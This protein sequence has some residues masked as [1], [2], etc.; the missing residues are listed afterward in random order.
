MRFVIFF[1]FF[2]NLIIFVSQIIIFVLNQ[3]IILLELIFL[4][5]DESEKDVN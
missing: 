1:L 5:N 4:D 3:E 2:I